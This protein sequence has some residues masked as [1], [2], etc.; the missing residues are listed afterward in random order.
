MA[1][2]IKCILCTEN[3]SILLGTFYN[4]WLFCIA[5]LMYELI[6][7]QRRDP[8]LNYSWVREKQYLQEYAKDFTPLPKWI[9]F[10]WLSWI[11]SP[12]VRKLDLLFLFSILQI[13]ALQ[14]KCKFLHFCVA[15]KI[16]G[17]YYYCTL[18]I[19][20]KNFGSYFYKENDVLSKNNFKAAF[21]FLD[22]AFHVVVL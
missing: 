19:F 15:W 14:R 3:M 7:M 10:C 16:F 2:Q 6:Q 8:Q 17:I 13:T 12:N 1:N 22:S 21:F 20:Q 4:Y 11:S 9:K 5:W 18:N